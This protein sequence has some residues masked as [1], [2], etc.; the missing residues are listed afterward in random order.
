MNRSGFY[1]IVGVVVLLLSASL[2]HGADLHFIVFADTTDTTIGTVVDV[3]NAQTWAQR[4]ADNT[5]LN[6]QFQSLTGSSLTAH[7]A[8]YKLNRLDTNADDVIYFFYSGHGANSGTSQWPVLTFDFD[9]AEP[10]IFF[11]EVVELLEP[12]NARLQII[13]ADCCN[14]YP[15]QVGRPLPVYVPRP[16]TPLEEENFKSLFLENQ[17]RILACGSKPGQF[18]LGAEEAGGL[19]VMMFMNAFVTLAQS[20]QNLTWNEIFTKTAADTTA[21]AALYDT[22]Q[23]PQYLIDFEQVLSSTPTGGN[24]CGPMGAGTIILG[25]IG[26]TFISNRRIRAMRP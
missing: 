4:I 16:G 6:L 2:G 23:E 25:M 11:D 3:N 19:F 18:S 21:E 5:G 9:S 22:K 24:G 7:N 26:F 20:Q 14:N 17:G 13:I 10:Y 1:R 12:K 8:R 15:D